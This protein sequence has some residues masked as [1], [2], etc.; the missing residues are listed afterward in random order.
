MNKD[1]TTKITEI[2]FLGFALGV[3]ALVLWLVLL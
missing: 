1:K 2:W 3:G